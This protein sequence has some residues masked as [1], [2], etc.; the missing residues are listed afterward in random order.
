MIKIPIH[1]VTDLVTNSS[2]VIYTYSEGSLKALEEMIDEFFRAFGIDKKCKD[3]FWLYVGLDD[4]YR[5]KD[6]IYYMDDDEEEEALKK[7]PKE[8]TDKDMP[9][10]DRGAFINK[11]IESVAKGE[12]PEPQWMRD[13]KED[14]D[15]YGLNPSTSLYIFP[16]DPA[17][18][19]LAKKVSRFLNS[20]T[21]EVTRDS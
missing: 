21:H 11:T 10:K 13:P 1:S 3:V 16:K 4:F 8:L 6:D 20:T 18:E 15:S 14:T 12:I 2:T 7:Y 19:D 9:D 17:H 5:I